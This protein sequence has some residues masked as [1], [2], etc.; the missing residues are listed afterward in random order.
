MGTGQLQPLTMSRRS[1]GVGS[2]LP[3]FFTPEPRIARTWNGRTAIS[4]RRPPPDDRC[5]QRRAVL[6]FEKE[7]DRLGPTAIMTCAHISQAVRH[8]GIQVTTTRDTSMLS[9]SSQFRTQRMRSDL[10]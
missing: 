5:D 4:Q 7:A 10:V 3:F 1:W 6:S 8:S 9:L 2:V